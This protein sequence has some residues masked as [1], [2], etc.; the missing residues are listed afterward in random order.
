M[1]KDYPTES[2]AIWLSHDK[3][4]NRLVKELAQDANSEEHLARMI[5]DFVEINNPL[6]NPPS[7]YQDILT[8]AL[9]NA[10]Y[11]QIAKEFLDE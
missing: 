2:I 8:N 11:R 9:I 3:E 1:Y 5:K 4:N 6:S 7:L 10:D